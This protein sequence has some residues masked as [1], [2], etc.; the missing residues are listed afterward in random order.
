MGDVG[1]D[2]ISGSE[3]SGQFD[4]RGENIHSEGSRHGNRY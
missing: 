2:A 1:E 3:R 4:G